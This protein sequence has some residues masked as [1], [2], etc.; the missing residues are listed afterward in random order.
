ML[1]KELDDSRGTGVI[2]EYGF[3]RFYNLYNDPKEEYPWTPDLGGALWVRWPMAE[4]L[5]EH[6]TSLQKE[7]PIKPGTLDPYHPKK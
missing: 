7:A 2:V 4:I 5:N 1:T 3:P 6:A